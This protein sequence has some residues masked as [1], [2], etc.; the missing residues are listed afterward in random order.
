M[1]GIPCP[2]ACAKIY[3]HKQ[4]L[5]DYLDACY[6]IGKYMEG[7][8]LKNFGVEGPNTWSSDDPCDP[9][10]SPV[11]RKALGKPKIARRREADKPTNPYKLTRSEYAMKCENYRRL[12][13]NYKG[14]QQPLNPD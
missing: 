6:T 5:E 13:H 1:N 2:Q 4:K 11:I 14:C 7:Y 3:L 10:M 8:A 9:I 12:G